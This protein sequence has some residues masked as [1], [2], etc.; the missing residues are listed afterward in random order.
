MTK[1]E[2]Y[3]KFKEDMEGAG[4]EVEDYQGRNFYDGPAVTVDSGELQEVIRTTTV[5]LQWDQMGRDDLVI[6]PR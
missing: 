2:R 4:Y 3:A 6:Y 1:E 5:A